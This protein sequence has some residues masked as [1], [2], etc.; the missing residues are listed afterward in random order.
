[1]NST[2]FKE[3]F[4][5]TLKHLEESSIILMDNASYHSSILENY[6]KSNTKKI[7]VQKWLSNKGIDFSLLET[8]CDLCERVKD[9]TPREK[10]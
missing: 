1:M 2:I 7:D 8:L 4:I 9:V 10:N 6:P 3:W 5:Q